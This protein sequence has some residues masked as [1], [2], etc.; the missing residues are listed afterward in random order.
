MDYA[1][2]KDKFIS[3]I[4]DSSAE[5]FS[6]IDASGNYQFVGGSVRHLLGY[7]PEDMI[8]RSALEYIH[9]AD[10][11]MV[12]AA[13]GSAIF[14]R[15]TDMPN[16][17][18]RHSNGSWRWIQCRI[19]NLSDNPDVRGY[20]TNSIDITDKVE[21]ERHQI[22]TQA[23]YESLFFNHPDTVFE[24]D[25]G[26]FFTL[27]NKNF[28]SLTGYSA[29]EIKGVHFR[30]LVVDNELPIAMNAFMRALEG[31]A[32]EVELSIVSPNR[33]VVNLSIAVVPVIINGDIVKIQGIA[34]DITL[35][36]RYDN[37][38][39]S[40]A[41]QLHNIMER[42][43]ESFFSLDTDWNY[44]YVNRFYCTYMGMGKEELIGRNIWELFP[45][46]KEGRF[47]A[48][49]LEV[50]KTGMPC[51]TEEV[52]PY[53]AST[54]ISV[55]VYSTGED[56]SVHFVDITE[57]KREQDRLE[58]LSLVASKTNTCI[59]IE[60]KHGQIE[61][62]NEAFENVMG[63]TLSEMLLKHPAETL[64]G[65]G[66][67]PETVRKLQ[68]RMRKGRGF[69]GEML[70]YTKSGEPIWFYQ[71]TTP[72]FDA[73]GELLKF[74]SIRTDITQRKAHEEELVKV[75]HD[76][77]RH[78]HD[79]QHFS[80]LVSH[81]LRAPAANIMGLSGLLSRLDK[82]TPLFDMTV[83]KIRKSAHNL[84]IV[85]RD[86]NH[87][88]SV[89]ENDFDVELEELDL[90]DVV[91]Q[92]L[93]SMRHKLYRKPCSVHVDIDPTL[94]L[95]ANRTYMIEILKH[96]L[97]NSAKFRHPNR[98]LELS[99]KSR[100]K[101]GHVVLELR[102]NGIGMNLKAVK[103]DLFKIYK[104]FHAGYDGRGIG[105]FLV[106]TYLELM[107]GD[108]RVSSVQGEG[109]CFKLTFKASV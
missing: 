86:M 4:M 34:R 19:T 109:S 57:K 71:E 97:S 93:D 72:V 94:R 21:G 98:E 107:K 14:N 104:K 11:D 68:K 70:N 80:Y 1:H 22:R 55:Q 6:V 37:Y 42:V 35:K 51:N 27:V 60:N 30:A 105:L 62:A 18:F 64:T 90:A 47:Y 16:F 61:W 5:L 108:I 58:K 36:K 10:K 78:N 2:L 99:I 53:N 87:V 59:L 28:E 91:D 103:G 79:L 52:S 25:R 89:R 23:H 13:L 106:K 50:A 75:T 92:A 33:K 3:S 81:N 31:S 76:L 44:T 41:D 67:N 96:L 65:P 73:D 45:E 102:D 38:L 24:L 15:S 46:A 66:T 8:G 54:T 49:C 43:P 20:I 56:I 85:I 88:L 39:K 17:R 26:G 40:Q 63:Y 77:F 101:A 83:D 84:D 74:I 9:P 48:T 69:R 7:A 32:H 82:N 29:E 95:C 12:G 100:T